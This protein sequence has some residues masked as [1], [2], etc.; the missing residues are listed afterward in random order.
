MKRAPAR[1]RY[2]GTKILRC[3]SIDLGG[4]N[5][6]VMIVVHMHADNRIMSHSG[7]CARFTFPTAD[8]K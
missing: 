2:T 7:D 4:S 3:M 6:I 5:D 1:V 8:G